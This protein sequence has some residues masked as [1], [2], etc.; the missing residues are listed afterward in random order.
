MDYNKINVVSCKDNL[1]MSTKN[2]LHQA[3][4]GTETRYLFS[5]ATCSISFCCQSI[6]YS[7]SSDKSAPSVS[8]LAFEEVNEN[9]EIKAEDYSSVHNYT[10]FIHIKGENVD[11]YTE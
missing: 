9:I 10:F 8:G 4:Q 3:Y 5:K 2:L 11:F 6:V 1:V 7:I